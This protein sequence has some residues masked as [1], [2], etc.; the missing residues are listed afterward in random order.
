MYH[1]RAVIALFFFLLLA[2]VVQAKSTLRISIVYDGKKST[3]KPFD[4]ALKQEIHALLDSDLRVTFPDSLQ[5]YGNYNVKKISKNV[6]LAART[7]YA[8]MMITVG[9]IA[10]NKLAKRRYINKPAIAAT[11]IDA[12]MQAL[13]QR[14]GR[15]TRANLT[16]ITL[17]GS[18]EQDIRAI[19][20][21]LHPKHVAI[22]IQ[23]EYRAVLQSYTKALI[24]KFNK[25]E[26]N[27]TVITLSDSIDKSLAQMPSSVDAV[28]I[29]PMFKYDEPFKK[30][31]FETLSLKELPTFSALGKQEVKEGALMSVTPKSSVKRLIRQ[32]TLDVE[33]LASGMKATSL[34][35]TFE[36]FPLLSIN[37]KSAHNIGFVPTWQLLSQA[38]VIEGESSDSHA[39]TIEDIMNRAITHNL[40]ALGSQYK[41][42]IAKSTVNKAMSRYLPQLHFGA[43]VAQVDQDR[44]TAS[45]GLLNEVRADAFITA[46][47]QVFNQ[48]AGAAISVNRHFLDAKMQLSEYIALETA[49]QSSLLFIDILQ[50]K[51]Q[52]QLQKDNLEH[53]KKNVQFA[54]YQK[55]TGVSNGSDL[56]RLKSKLASDKKQVLVTH[57]QLQ[58]VRHTLNAL[59]D[60]PQN[61]RLNFMK[62]D[63]HDPVFMTHHQDIEEQFNDE[64]SFLQFEE[65][66]VQGGLKKVP[67]LKQYSAIKEARR[68]I[69]ES[70]KRAFY[71]PTL[72]IE[73]GVRQ[74]F[75]SAS[76]DVRNSDVNLKKYPYADNTDWEIGLFLRYPLYTGGARDADVQSSKAAF[77]VAQS[78]EKAVHNQVEKDIRNTLYQ[79]KASYLSI[80][81][82]N[83]AAVQARKNLQIIQS[84]YSQGKSSI[85]T[86]LDAQSNALRSA[87]QANST[88]YGFM[89]DLLLLQ[90][91]IGQVNFN[92]DNR[93][94]SQWIAP[95]Q[96]E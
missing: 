75:I 21:Y 81:L 32:I 73:G 31:L 44:A 18:V 46:S 54:Q 24:R 80:K 12:A 40:D 88:R 7:Q 1:S 66:L 61:L 11:I 63:V 89:H 74:H 6:N 48:R 8:D 91:N 10:S 2:T 59:L 83:E 51:T 90:F 84:R 43:E 4:L 3:Y 41:V 35:T 37:M 76:N 94:Y 17:Q 23:S 96:G 92:M 57:S 26:M 67:S 33:Q 58:Q 65:F 60:L 16:F 56:Y 93:Q 22:L 20:R 38:S 79:S 70:D 36:V 19:K 9:V 28:Y 53:T 5:L 34:K 50:L 68:A 27:A 49:L 77:L 86:L 72:S 47:Q 25:Q 42:D 85:V 52:L 29:T 45:L 95:L 71:T 82:A 13:P 87:L 39:F 30:E 64:R 15:S 62:P 14:N 69:Y 55:K 78:Q